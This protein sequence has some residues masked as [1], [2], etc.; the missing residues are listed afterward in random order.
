MNAGILILGGLTLALA[1]IAFIKDPD[2]YMI[3]LIN[4]KEACL[5]SGENYAF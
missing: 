4:K 1:I 3:E 5:H 2:G